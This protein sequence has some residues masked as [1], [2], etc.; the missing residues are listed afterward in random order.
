M[1]LKHTVY[2]A[3]KTLRDKINEKIP[4][5]R[6]PPCTPSKYLFAL[7]F[8]TRFPPLLTSKLELAF[9]LTLPKW[10]PC[11][12]LLTTTL[13]SGMGKKSSTNSRTNNYF[14]VKML[15]ICSFIFVDVPLDTGEEEG[16]DNVGAQ[17]RSKSKSKTTSKKEKSSKFGK[18]KV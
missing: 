2:Y 4:T 16:D 14:Y 18:L 13:P 15:L 1:H 12:F 11:D 6:F 3:A 5:I 9:T 17:T 8:K 7:S 10:L